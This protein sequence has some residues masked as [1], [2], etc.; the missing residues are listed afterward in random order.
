VIKIIKSISGKIQKNSGVKACLCKVGGVS[1][2]TER[3]EAKIVVSTQY[4]RMWQAYKT[5]IYRNSA[6]IVGVFIFLSQLLTWNGYQIS[7]NIRP[8]DRKN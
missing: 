2:C 7:G 1:K 4:C 5:K 8:N 3:S 6:A